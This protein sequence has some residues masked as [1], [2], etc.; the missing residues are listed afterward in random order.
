[1]RTKSL[2]YIALIVLFAA[3][4]FLSCEG[5]RRG[6]K[7]SRIE[8]DSIV[9]A[10]QIPLL[11]ENDTTLPFADVTVSFTYPV[12]FRDAESLARL[13]QIFK[14]TFFGDME[15]DSLPPKE[16]MDRYVSNYS[17]RYKSL[18]NFY[19]EDMARLENN[20][21]TWYWYYMSTNNKIL[22]QNDSILS[23]AVEYSDYE[24]GAHGSYRIIYTNI[25]LNELVTISEEDLFVPDYFKRLTDK[26][27]QSLMKQYDA[28]S[29]NS[30][31]TNGF[32]TIEDIVPNNNFW[33]SDNGIHY[34]YNEYE[35]APYAMGVI[36]VVVPYSELTEII[37]PNG[38]IARYFTDK[39]QEY[40]SIIG[41]LDKKNKVGQ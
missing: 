40:I 23:C 9:V 32:F 18:S 34:S 29:P 20:I 35:I 15:Y 1:M 31:L 39:R 21:P 26:I 13:E 38:I 41:K 12:K 24:G 11:V 19:Y 28:E 27:V 7:Y 6:D 14:G 16:A 17:E 25:D 33:L 3:S 2:F 10:K 22:F 36:D 30:L 8:Y 37:S 5:N 4:V